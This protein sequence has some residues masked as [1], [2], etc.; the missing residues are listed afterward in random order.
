[1]RLLL[2]G[3]CLFACAAMG[4]NL[5]AVQSQPVTAPASRPAAA[6]GD[7]IGELMWQLGVARSLLVL[8]KMQHT[9]HVPALALMADWTALLEGTYADGH[10][11]PN[12]G[13]GPYL[14]EV[15]VNPLTAASKVVAA[16]EAAR[17]AGWTY[18]EGSGK[19]RAVIP[20]AEMGQAAKRLLA[21]DYEILK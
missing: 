13:F 18:D 14:W 12:G 2:A 4:V 15:L 3:G 8:Y 10:T 1:M 7:R 6:K 21:T 9:E 11:G 16:G 17:G 5:P 19:L 20:A